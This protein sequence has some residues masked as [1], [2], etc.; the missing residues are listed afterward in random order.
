MNF[1]AETYREAA[2]DRIRVAR[3]LY[4]VRHYVTAHYLAGVAV[5]CLLRAY[6]FRRN[7]EFDSRH[8]LWALYRDS[9]I[10]G[11]VEARHLFRLTDLLGTVAFQWNNTHR[12]RSEKQF[13]RFLKQIGADRGIRG[14]FVKENARRVVAAAEEFIETGVDSWTSS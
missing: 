3:A 8:D 5:E 6:R 12:Y 2:K 11:A 4:K 10:R 14:D 9:G 13:Q 7:P 1:T